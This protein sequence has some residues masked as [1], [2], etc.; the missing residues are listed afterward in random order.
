M[1]VG[2]PAGERPAV[3]GGPSV[4]AAAG[5]SAEIGAAA[6]AGGG[7]VSAPER[8]QAYQPTAAAATSAASATPGGRPERRAGATAAGPAPGSAGADSGRAWPHR[9]ASTR[10]GTCRPQAGQVH[11]KLAVCSSFILAGL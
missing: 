6:L 2:S 7:V 5:V 8:D 11:V 9:H 1:P 4:G 10:L 3:A